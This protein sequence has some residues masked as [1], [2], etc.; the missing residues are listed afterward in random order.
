MLGPFDRKS[1]ALQAA[2]YAL[3]VPGEP[4]MTMYGDEHDPGIEVHGGEWLAA[5]DGMV[6]GPYFSKRD[7]KRELVDNL[8]QDYA[9]PPGYVVRV[10]RVVR[11]YRSNGKAVTVVAEI[12]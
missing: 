11:R 8:L 1:H 9:D 6:S 7:A 12:V 2:Q 5:Q 10:V 4:W 3:E